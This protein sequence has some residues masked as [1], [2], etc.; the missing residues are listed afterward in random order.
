MKNKDKLIIKRYL[1]GNDLI[2]YVKPTLTAST[3]LT[4]HKILITEMQTYNEVTI[5]I[6]GNKF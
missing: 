4:K 2:C 5:F 3:R 1:K 6:F